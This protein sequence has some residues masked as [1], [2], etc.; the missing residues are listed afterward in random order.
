MDGQPGRRRRREIESHRELATK[1]GGNCIFGRELILLAVET[2]QEPSIRAVLRIFRLH[3]L[4]LCRERCNPELIEPRKDTR[5]DVAA[6]A[7]SIG[8][9]LNCWVAAV[10]VRQCVDQPDDRDDADY[11]VFPQRVL[12]VHFVFGVSSCATRSPRAPSG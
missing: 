4:S 11:Q 3:A 6:H 7:A 9:D 1:L 12:V 10:Q 5:F 8:G 2:E